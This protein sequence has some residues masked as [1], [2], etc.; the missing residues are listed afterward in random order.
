MSQVWII[1]FSWGALVALAGG[2][3]G[4]W[5]RGRTTRPST[6]APATERKAERMLVEDYRVL[7]ESL[8][9]SLAPETLAT[10]LEIAA[11]PDQVRGYGHV[12]A[13]AVA[14]YHAR[15]VQLLARIKENKVLH[16]TAA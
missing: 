8:A 6:Q 16:R 15:K 4:W 13:R 2:V 12:K 1:E 3:A 11:L 7:V 9:P 14:D 5:L 10:A